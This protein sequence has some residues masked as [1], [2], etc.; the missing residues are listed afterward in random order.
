MTTI[1]K[2]WIQVLEQGVRN[3][4]IGT[5][6]QWNESTPFGDPE[7]L[8]ENI[9]KNGYYVYS[10]PIAK[11]PQAERENRESPLVQIAIKLSGAIHSSNVIVNIQR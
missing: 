6:L 4:F 5:G 9:E 2:A 3:G 8:Q 11:Q 7:T 10:I 1:K